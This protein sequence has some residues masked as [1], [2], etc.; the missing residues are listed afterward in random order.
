MSTNLTTYSIKCKRCEETQYFLAKP[1][2]INKWMEGVKIQDALPYLT[3]DERELIISNI[4]PTCW[5]D[6]FGGEE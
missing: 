4:C 3:P 2:D 5:I 1:I 6:L